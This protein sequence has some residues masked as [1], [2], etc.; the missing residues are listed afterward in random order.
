MI[1][2]I[3]RKE[4]QVL[5]KEKGTFFWLFLLPVLFIVMFSAIFGNTSQTVTVRYYDADRTVASKE[6]IQALGGIKGFELKQDDSQSLEAQIEDIRSGK[7]SSL[8]VVLRGMA[9]SMKAGPQQKLSC[10]GMRRRTPL[11][12][13]L[14]QC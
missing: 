9:G 1:R 12:R 4:I 6:L 3:V 8:V 14:W 5:I 2:S 13:R 7:L 10:T 11:W